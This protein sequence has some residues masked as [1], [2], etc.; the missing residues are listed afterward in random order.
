MP[1]KKP[2]STESVM[3]EVSR[4][5]P[6]TWTVSAWVHAAGISRTSEHLLPEEMKP[7]SITIGKTRKIVEPP[8]EWAQ[9]IARMQRG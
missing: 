9:R 2:Y 3:M 4:S 7:I 1:T 5:G 8:H 6:A